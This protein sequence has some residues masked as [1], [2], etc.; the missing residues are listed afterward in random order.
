M[1]SF[2][3][4]YKLNANLLAWHAEY[5]GNDD[6][7]RGLRERLLNGDEDTYQLLKFDSNGI[8]TIGPV[9]RIVQQGPARH[10]LAAAVWP[11]TDGGGGT[12]CGEFA[13]SFRIWS[14]LCRST[15][16][17]HAHA[18]QIAPDKN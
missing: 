2:L 10:A 9:S 3:K 12:R 8:W 15:F 11:Q 13:G 16:F 17:R 1:E 18:E 7:E 5:P 4:H 14:G 6:L